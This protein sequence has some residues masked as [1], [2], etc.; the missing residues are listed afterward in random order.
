MKKSKKSFRPKTQSEE[1]LKDLNTGSVSYSN[2]ETIQLIEHPVSSA[3]NSEP[4]PLELI[5]KARAGIPKS[6]MFLLMKQLGLAL[7]DI[8]EILHISE[9]TLHRYPNNKKLD[10]QATER[11]LQLSVLIAKGEHV[12]GDPNKFR[13]WMN[14]PYPPFAM[15]TPMSLLDTTFGFQLVFD[16]LT[17]IEHGIFA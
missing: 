17:R 5:K 14:F 13:M 9:R 7:K 16:Q 6:Q 1:T 10:V 12:F 2:S 15:K 4:A 8:S 3:Y 11:L